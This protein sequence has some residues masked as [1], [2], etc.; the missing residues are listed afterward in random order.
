M[1]I[2]EFGRELRVVVMAICAVSVLSAQVATAPTESQDPEAIDQSWQKASSKFDE[3]RAALLRKVE[4]AAEA[5]SDDRSRFTSAGLIM[6][7]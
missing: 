3:N 1:R 5:G 7:C 6:A 4:P 2:A